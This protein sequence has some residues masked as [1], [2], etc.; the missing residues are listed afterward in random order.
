M[1]WSNG[2][3][4]GGA[5][6]E[7]RMLLTSPVITWLFIVGYSLVGMASL[8]GNI[9]VLIVILAKKDMHT[10]T[11]VYIGCMS[12]AD[13]TVT[14]FSLWAT[15]FYHHRSSQPVQPLLHIV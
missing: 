9:A 12:V 8:I 14:L 4:C 11:N 3:G 15:P 5:S 1:N 2:F 6:D 7:N 10:S 13:L